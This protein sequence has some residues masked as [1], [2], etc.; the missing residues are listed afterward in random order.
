MA[1]HHSFTRV[2]FQANFGCYPEQSSVDIKLYGA[3][4]LLILNLPAFVLL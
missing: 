2:V 3:A 1:L 4:P